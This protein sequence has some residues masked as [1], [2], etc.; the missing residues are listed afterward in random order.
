MTSADH[1]D[2]TEPAVAYENIIIGDV[3]FDFSDDDRNILLETL[4]DLVAEAEMWRQPAIALWSSRTHGGSNMLYRLRR[5]LDGW[6]G[7]GRTW[8]T[9][10]LRPKVQPRPGRS[11]Q[12]TVRT[13]LTRAWAWRRAGIIGQRVREYDIAPAGDATAAACTVSADIRACQT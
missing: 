6:Y 3:A 1:D 9:L 8:Y 5:R 2:A 11:G 4:H 7:D 13:R 12:E 10:R